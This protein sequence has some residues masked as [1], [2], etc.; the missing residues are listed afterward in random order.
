V[1]TRRQVEPLGLVYYSDN[2]HLIAYCRLRRDVRDFRTDRI[3]RIQLQNELFSGHADFSLN[4]YLEAASKEG[5][6]ETAKVLFKPEVV[7]RVR[8]EW[9]CR[10]VE[11]K[12]E[13]GGVVVTLLAYSLDWLARWVF[14]FGSSAEVLAPDRLKQ[15]VAAEA[16][17]VAAKY[18]SSRRTSP[19]PQL[20]ESLLT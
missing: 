17:S 6:F 19:S 8:Q 13:R 16:Q 18:V 5:K 11:E 4:R 12:P 14:S 7:E 15:L 20:M 2:W 3:C 1:L 10:L 9:F